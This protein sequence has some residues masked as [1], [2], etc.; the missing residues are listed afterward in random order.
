MILG[1]SF[2]L[3]LRSYNAAYSLTLDRGDEGDC[4]YKGQDS[5]SSTRKTL[6]GRCACWVG[7]LRI[8]DLGALELTETSKPWPPKDPRREGKV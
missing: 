1:L 4:D 8:S 7:S 2:V 5:R 6:K 3:K